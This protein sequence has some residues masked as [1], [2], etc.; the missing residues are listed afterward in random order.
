MQKGKVQNATNQH[1]NAKLGDLFSQTVGS[2]NLYRRYCVFTSFFARAQKQKT[3]QLLNLRGFPFFA[4]QKSG[5]RGIRT[6]GTL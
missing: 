3:P 5:E 6:P 2:P 4:T 1:K